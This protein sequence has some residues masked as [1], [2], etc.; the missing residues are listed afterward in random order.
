M[1]NSCLR[2]E[3]LQLLQNQ[4]LLSPPPIVQ[5]PVA[6]ISLNQKCPEVC[7]TLIWDTLLLSSF[8][9]FFL[10]TEYVFSLVWTV[11]ALAEMRKI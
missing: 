3:K 1:C 2:G 5:Q 7:Q 8:D 9:L 10:I 4:Q 6:Q 11:I